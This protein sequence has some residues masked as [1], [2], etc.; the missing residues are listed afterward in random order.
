MLLFLSVPKSN[1]LRKE[2]GMVKPSLQIPTSFR[3]PTGPGPPYLCLTIA[4]SPNEDMGDVLRVGWPRGVLE[5][6]CLDG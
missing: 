5:K 3:L 6:D 4:A 1:V 2:A